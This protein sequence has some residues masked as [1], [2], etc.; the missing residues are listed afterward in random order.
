M[1]YPDGA[2]QEDRQAISVFTVLDSVLSSSGLRCADNNGNT[3][4]YQMV[5]SRVRGINIET[6]NTLINQ[7]ETLAELAG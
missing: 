5:S 6:L 2:T 7:H 3:D 4:Y 1:K